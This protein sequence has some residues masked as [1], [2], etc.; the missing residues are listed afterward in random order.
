MPHPD[1][2]L[3]QGKELPVFPN[4]HGL[5]NVEMDPAKEP[6]LLAFPT[7]SPHYLHLHITPLE[8]NRFAEAWRGNEKLG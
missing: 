7:S 8:L 4:Q 6:H 3:H 1:N 2:Q 5:N